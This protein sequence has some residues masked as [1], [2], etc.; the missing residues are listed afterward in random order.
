MK[1]KM[2]FIWIFTGVT[3]LSFSQEVS[4]EVFHSETVYTQQMVDTIL[5]YCRKN[6][7]KIKDYS[8]LKKILSSNNKLSGWSYY[9]YFKAKEQSL[10]RIH[11][12]SVIYANKGIQFYEN[13]KIKR[14]FDEAIL[15]ETHFYKGKSLWH[16][17]R[18]EEA[19]ESNQKALDYTKKYP[20]KWRSFI[21]AA[22]ANNHLEIGNDSIALDYYFEISR[23]SLFM[24]IDRSAVTSYTRIGVIYSK[25]NMIEK[26][27]LYFFKAI[28]RSKESGYTE[29]LWALYHNLGD[30]YKDEKNVDSTLFYY[31]KTIDFQDDF[32]DSQ[33]SAINILNYLKGTIALYEND[34]NHAIDYFNEIIMYYDEMPK[35]KDEKDLLMNVYSTLGD[36]YE[37]TNNTVG[38]TKVLEESNRFLEEFYNE[39][40]ITNFNDLE[41]KY[42]TKEKDISI[43]SLEATTQSQETIIQQRNTINWILGGLLLSFIGLGYLF[44]RQRRLQNH[45]KTSNLEQRLLRSQLNP[46]FLFNALN[47]VSGLVQKKSDQTI[48]YISRLGNLLRSILENSREEFITLVEE[49]ETIT[50]YLELQSD[51]SKKFTFDVEIISDLNKEELL[52]PPMFLQPFIENAIDHGFQGKD[53]EKITITVEQ[54]SKDQVLYF[55]IEDNGIGYSNAMKNKEQAF[56]HQSL[57]G[58]ILK[59]RL[60]LYARA[61]KKK[62]HYVIGD[63]VTG[64]GTRVELWLPYLIED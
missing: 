36:A 33:I 32:I 54:K 23:D 48:P 8:G 37:K 59:E 41:I 15:L 1:L 19:I 51:F 6:A 55:I 58:T 14:E 7:R 3:T 30:I 44:Y 13:S 35:S 49:L 11:D 50:S 43:A 10:G 42:K 18:F 47:S 21:V 12:S 57:S 5:V 20:Y 25:F 17:Q 22:I 45:Y 27:K 4:P 40:L 31:K 60:D 29:N 46:H 56:G 26:A 16:L 39:Q 34:A 53:D 28:K 61:F 24:S 52:I 63:I 2:L 9:Y 64:G 38:L 62:A